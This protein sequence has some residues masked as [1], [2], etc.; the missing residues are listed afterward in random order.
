MSAYIYPGPGDESD[1][2]RRLLAL[3]DNPHEVQ[4]SSDDGLAFRVPED[5][6]ERYHQSLLGSATPPADEP[7]AKKTTAPRRRTRKEGS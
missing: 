1:V 7:A 6:A 4:T 5:L 2:A 3:T